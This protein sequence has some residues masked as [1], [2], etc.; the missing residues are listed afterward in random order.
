MPDAE[1]AS[2]L[3]IIKGRVQGVF[4]RAFTSKVARSLGLKGYV[5]NLPLG[6]AVEVYAEGDKGKLEELIR[7]L[8]I[9]PPG[10]QVDKIDVNWASYS[11]KFTNFEIRY[12]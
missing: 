3:A 5:R 2:F 9:G 1:M 6:D 12:R 7:Y 4:F 10:A 11:G 8:K